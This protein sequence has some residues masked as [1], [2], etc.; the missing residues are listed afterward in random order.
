[1]NDG[2]GAVWVIAVN[3]A[4]LSLIAV[5][6]INPILPELH[7]QVVDVYGWMSSARFTDLFAIA[8]GAPGPNILVVTLIGWDVAGLSGAMAATLAICGP[9][10]VLAFFVSQLWDRFRAARWRLALQAGLVPVTIGLVAAGA[11]VVAR[12]ADTS[13]AAFLITAGTAVA[14]YWTPLHPLWFLA[15]GAALGVVGLI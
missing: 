14:L 9:S 13:A 2:E 3:F 1:M 11:Y 7:R 6:G 10:S 15:A 8:Q 4:I 5:G 12:A